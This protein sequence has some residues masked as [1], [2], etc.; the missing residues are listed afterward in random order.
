MRLLTI[1]VVVL[2]ALYSGYWF[3]GARA[4]AGALETQVAELQDDGWTVDY[5]A[6]NTAG[7]PS[8]FDTTATNL[9]VADPAGTLSYEAPLL[10]MLTLSYQ[11]NRVIVAFPDTHK[12][13]VPQI[14]AIDV[15]SNGLRASANVGV[16]TAL[17]LRN[18]TAEAESMTLENAAGLGVT[19]QN[20]LIALREGAGVANTYDVYVGAQALQLPAPLMARLNPT[21]ILPDSI[22]VAKVDG[23]VTLDRPLD[24]TTTSEWARDPAQVQAFALRDLALTWGNLMI[25][26]DGAVTL[27]AAGMPNGTITL[28]ANDWQQ[29]LDIAIE[30]NLVPQNAVFLA[31]SMGQSLSLGAQDLTVPVAFADGRWSIAGFDLG[32]APQLQ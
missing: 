32:P 9:T 29:M 4:L 20:L 15:T 27:D 6:L 13:T 22:K 26:G 5:E 16:S 3:L 17:P 23:A 18:V 30:A 31:R 11:P 25:S 2:A 7:F 19:L 8:R 28:R 24:R 14:G 21:G 1:V 12:V 10:Q